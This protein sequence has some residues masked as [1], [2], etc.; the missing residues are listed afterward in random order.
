MCEPITA[1][2]AASAAAGTAATATAA[3]AATATAATAATTTAAA[4][5]FG[6]GI[7]WST[8]GSIASLAGSAFSAMSQMEAGKAAKNAADYNAKMG[9]IQ[10][11]DVI[12]RAAIEQEKHRQKVRSLRGAQDVNAAASGVVVGSG[13]AGDI[14]EQTVVLGKEDEFT[15]KNNAMRQA[16]G[17]RAQAGLDYQQG[18]AAQRKGE[19]DAAGT[20]LT[21]G[22]RT[23]GSK[24]WK[25]LA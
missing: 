20:L 25:D 17:Y 5:A 18:V 11:Q 4:G 21:A 19:L 2:A 3:T 22:A 1:T 7:S 12:N 8:I 9:E 14:A 10:A 24:W 15:I 23:M 16:W 6:T 13:S